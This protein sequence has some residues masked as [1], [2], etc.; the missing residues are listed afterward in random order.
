MKAYIIKSC[1]ISPQDSFGNT[2]PFP[3]ADEANDILK[4]IEPTYKEHFP[5]MKIRRMGRLMKMCITAA[6]NCL[7]HNNEIIQP[8]ALLTASAWGCLEDTFK[9]LNDIEEGS[10]KIPSPATFINSTHNTPG[11]QIALMFNIQGYNNV[12][13]NGGTSFEDALQDAL[14]LI[15]EGKELI[16]LGG[17]DELSTTDTDLKQ[18]AD[19]YKNSAYKPGE[20]VAFFLLSNK[21]NKSSNHIKFVELLSGTTN[22]NEIA[23]HLMHLLDKE[24]LEPSSIDLVLSG[25]PTAKLFESYPCLAYKHTCGEY[26]TSSSYAV[27]LANKILEHQKLPQ[28][29][30]QLITGSNPEG[31]INNILVYNNS[32]EDRHAFTLVSKTNL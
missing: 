7:N 20:G 24:Q 29:A 18:R 14:L 11:G 2:Y 4:C 23:T 19:H 9:F 5:P 21:P 3:I 22:E 1:A 13:V 31:S 10:G 27:W 6:K 28:G 12:Y 30:K 17:F 25:T 8:E 32:E 16:L 15:R 26:E